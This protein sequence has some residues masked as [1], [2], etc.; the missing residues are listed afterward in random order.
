MGLCMMSQRRAYR[1][2]QSRELGV[3]LGRF[4]CMWIG[5][6]DAIGISCM[7]VNIVY[8]IQ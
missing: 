2:Y 6:G 1:I 3:Y 7:E 4:R 5:N 8:S